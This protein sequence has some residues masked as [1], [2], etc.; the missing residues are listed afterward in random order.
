MGSII[1]IFSKVQS[2]IES[3]LINL[4]YYP[5]NNLPICSEQ[6]NINLKY[7]ISDFICKILIHEHRIKS[8]N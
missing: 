1:L 6:T 3:D 7:Y 5:F 8:E 4:V 2:I